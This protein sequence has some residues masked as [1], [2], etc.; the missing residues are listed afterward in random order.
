VRADGETYTLSG[1]ELDVVQGAKGDFVVQ[2]EGGFTLALD[3][4]L[5]PELRAEGLARELVN[6]VQKL[7]KDTGLEVS[8]RIRL[9]VFGGAELLDAAGRN[10]E[11]VMGET[12]ATEIETG[13]GPQADGYEA[14]R[15]VDLDGVTATIALARVAP[16]EPK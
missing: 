8:D 7:R 13:P 16:T 15:E 9:G 11:M 2:S 3:P 4:T 5:T 6:R 1:D 14:V 10:G 12:L